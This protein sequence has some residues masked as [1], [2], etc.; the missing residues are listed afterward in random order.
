MCYSLT[1]DKLQGGIKVKVF[2]DCEFTQ[3]R[4]DS[5]LISL[6]MVADNGKEFYAEFTDFDKSLV[7]DWIED[8][9]M[10]N[11][12]F[13]DSKPFKA[14]VGG[15]TL[16]KEDKH[17]IQAAL[18]SWL[19]QFDTV[20]L[21]SDVHHYDVVLLF[22]IF[23]HAFKIPHNVY[24]IPFDIA[25]MFK[26]LGLDPDTDRETFIDKPIKGDKHNAL[27]DSRVIQACYD[28]LIRNREEYL[29]NLK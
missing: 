8:N 3:L 18:A 26:T 21:W 24:Y 4:K 10:K 20:E 6:G 16:I 17:M 13:R 23:G 11:L 22:D 27:Y 29:K 25:T 12:L 1:T 15:V 14:I 2:F 9:V 5:T 7:D 28:K 19:A